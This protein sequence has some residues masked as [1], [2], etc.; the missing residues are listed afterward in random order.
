MVTD[1]IACADSS[2][3]QVT[4]IVDLVV[5]Q[6][7]PPFVASGTSFMEDNFSMDGGGGWGD[8]SGYNGRDG[9]PRGVADETSLCRL[10]L[11]FCCAAW[12]LTG[13]RLV[14]VHGLGVGDRCV[15]VFKDAVD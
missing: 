9:E 11:T 6:Q 14:P 12:P 2:L 1:C 10:P 7:S 15:M 4:P 13:H 8:G 3:L 5:R